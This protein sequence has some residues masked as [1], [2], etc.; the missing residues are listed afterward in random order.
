MRILDIAAA[1]DGMSRPEAARCGDMT[2]Q[3]LHDAIRRYSSVRRDELHELGRSGRP[4]KFSEDQR[5]DLRDLALAGPDA[6]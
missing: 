5:L 6:E 2:D 1:I 3:A 4:C